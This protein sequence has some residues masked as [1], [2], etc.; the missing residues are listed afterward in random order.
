MAE[1][2]AKR[3]AVIA[4]VTGAL[5]GG[6]VAGV[7]GVVATSGNTSTDS[8]S[9]AGSSVST[10]AVVRT[11]LT[12]AVQVG[13]SIGYDGSYTITAPSGVSAQTV[14]G[15]Q[16]AVTLDQQQLSADERAE[17]DGSSADNQATAA[18]QAGV[19]TD[20]S[21]LSSDQAKQ[22]QD[23]AAP[24]ASSP[25]CSQD[26]LKV[27]QDQTQLTQAQQQLASAQS[28]ATRD[29]DQNQAKVAGDQTKLQGDQTT[30]ASDQATAVNP[31]TTYTSL[32]TV[33]DV[34][35]EDQ[36]VYSVSIEPVPLLYGSVPAFRAF[37]TG[38]SDG[39]DVGEL[40][41]DL[42]TL[43]YGA[44]LTQSN[45]F[46]SSTATAVERWQGALGL[47]ATGDISLGEVVFE[48]GP[49]RVTSVTPSV[50]QSVGGAG[51]AGAGGGGGTVLTATSTT[52]IVA[53]PLDV[54]QQYLVKPGDAVSVVLPDGTSTVG[55]HVETVGNV[56]TCP[57]GGG[58][59]TG[60]GTGTSSG[61][62]DQ[63]PCESAGSGN[64]SNPTVT[65]TITLDST[66]PGA[67]LDQAPVNVNITTQRA[68][69]VLAVPVNALLALQGGGFGVQVVTGNSSH[70]AGVI[71]G[72]YSN[73]LVQVSGSGIAAGTRV[74]VPSS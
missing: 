3:I 39:A 28:A 40:T 52:P 56:A 27:S 49:I 73:T 23:C 36:P 21:T 7:V 26:A 59:G 53:V 14:D 51:G 44:G 4:A 25:A 31:G 18:A 12:T 58:T 11:D 62:A 61:S 32:P 57:G 17:A 24:G 37:S 43:G 5:M 74:E 65:V 15:A 68:D 46:S 67:T 22:T 45:H 2:S 16:Q 42:I 20:Q 6:A 1:F 55:G 35:R 71:T 41:Q 70:L 48:P 30:L 33:G 66:P 34:I 10:A 9:G 38:M 72:L 69:D 50:G 8:S 60:T 19:N 64:S 54:S 47:P 29:Q 13:G 63:S